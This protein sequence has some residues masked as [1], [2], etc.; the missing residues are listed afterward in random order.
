[1]HERGEK[2]FLTREYKFT[3]LT[4]SFCQNA[5]IRTIRQKDMFR[6]ADPLLLFAAPLRQQ[7]CCCSVFFRKRD[8]EVV[9]GAAVVVEG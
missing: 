2:D 1:M 5:G 6:P 7:D 9:S 3:L 8:S 4:E